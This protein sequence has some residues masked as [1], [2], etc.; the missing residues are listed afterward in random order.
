MEI[1]INLQMCMN[2]Y[3]ILGKEKKNNLLTTDIIKESLLKLKNYYM[4]E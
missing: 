1:F 4:A 2:S 3:L